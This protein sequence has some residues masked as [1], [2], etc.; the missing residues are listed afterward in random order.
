M[1][2]NYLLAGA[3]LLSALA[4]HA[5]EPMFFVQLSDPQLGMYAKNADCLQEEENLLFAVE[6][7]NR[8][9][10]MFV[11]VTG[12]LVNKTGDES[13]IQR[14]KELIGRVDPSIP[15]YNVPG[16]HDVGN[17][18]T[19]K[20]LAQYRKSF[21]KDYYSFDA[22]SIR[23]IVLD[24]SLLGSPANA[25]I[26]ATAQ[27]KWLSS[28]LA[29]AKKDM[30]EPIVFLH[31]SFFL[32][33]PQEPDQYFNIPTQI[34]ARYLKLL[35]EYGVKHVFAGHH[36]RNDYG[37][38]GDLEVVTTSALGMPLGPNQSGMRIVRVTNTTV[39]N[40]YYELGSLPHIIDAGKPLPEWP[41][42]K[43]TP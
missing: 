38:D 33:D 43:S 16:N 25:S 28:E 18:P 3:C 27:E 7:I 12:D 8:L 40:R 9:K 30:V 34:R 6:N 15:V 17:Q 1:T 14:Y 22:G 37:R 26:E 5:A 11:V 36:H 10:P 24:S 23:G 19:D 20:Q 13:Q 4:L 21:G 39:E 31:I 2:R 42:K 41:A 35:H 29:R 32:N